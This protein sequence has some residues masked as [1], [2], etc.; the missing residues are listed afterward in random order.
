MFIYPTYIMPTMNISASVDNMLKMMFAETMEECVK[1]LSIKYN[2]PEEEALEFLNISEL[3]QKKVIGKLCGEK[4]E[5]K[6]KKEV[7]PNKP[8]KTSGYL[9]YS[10][11]VRQSVKEELLSSGKEAKPKDVVQSIAAKWKELSDE[12]KSVW[13]EKAKATK[14]ELQ[15][16]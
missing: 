15:V 9:L 16:N 6:A 1:Q 2:F 4:K 7:D 13:N 3:K 12:E 8:K 10:S 5:K 11:D 14:E